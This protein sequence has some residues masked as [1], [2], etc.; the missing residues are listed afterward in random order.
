MKTT[1]ETLETVRTPFAAVTPVLWRCGEMVGVHRI[2]IVTPF[3][4]IRIGGIA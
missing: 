3:G 4:V 2:E 1:I